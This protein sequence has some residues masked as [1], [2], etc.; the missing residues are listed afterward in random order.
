MLRGKQLTSLWKK[1]AVYGLKGIFAYDSRRTFSF[2]PSVHS[3]KFLF[4]EAGGAAQG[5]QAVG[6]VTRRSLAEVLKLRVC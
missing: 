5:A 2:E 6:P 4:S 3:F 1:L